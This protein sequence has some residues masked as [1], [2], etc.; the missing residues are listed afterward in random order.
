MRSCMILGIYF[1]LSW[2][3]KS[4]LKNDKKKRRR[5]KG[6]EHEMCE[7]ES[8]GTGRIPECQ[9]RFVIRAQHFE[10]FFCSRSLLSKTIEYIVYIIIIHKL[11]SFS[12]LSKSFLC[13]I[14]PFSSYD[15]EDDNEE[16]N[17]QIAAASGRSNLNSGSVSIAESPLMLS[18]S[19]SSS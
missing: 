16:E 12:S 19:S 1:L 15:D 5:I 18:S 11:L 14:F 9:S 4:R 10:A 3:K 6:W 8:W 7:G 2:A 17:H 13:F